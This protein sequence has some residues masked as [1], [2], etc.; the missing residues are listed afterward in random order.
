MQTPTAHSSYFVYVRVPWLILLGAIGA[1]VFYL[2][3]L[4][5]G[6]SGRSS[7]YTAFCVS[8]LWILLSTLL[9][10]RMPKTGMAEELSLLVSSS[11]VLLTLLG[12]SVLGLRLRLT[13][14][15]PAS[16]LCTC[17]WFVTVWLQESGR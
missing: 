16:L 6:S 13:L 9:L 5:A 15:L 8:A 10:F 7:L 3:G 12:F 1:L 17:V 11:L 4:R 14:A 2:A